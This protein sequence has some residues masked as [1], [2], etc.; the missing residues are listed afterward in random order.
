[1]S[2]CCLGCL[3][4][5][6]HAILL[7]S[8]E[9]RASIGDV[10]G[11]CDNFQVIVSADQVVP[12]RTRIGG[13]FDRT[14]AVVKLCAALSPEERAAWNATYAGWQA[15]AAQDVSWLN[16][17]AIARSMC[18]MGAA[19]EREREALRTKC[20]AVGPSK[21]VNQPHEASELGSTLKWV[22]G[23][24]IVVAGVYALKSF[25]P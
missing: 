11:D 10:Y 13:E 7:A 15:L 8:E 12:F 3:A 18:A 19:L 25:L 17:N 16:A 22:A 21:V 5:N 1:M 24:A 4:G 14:D 9:R 23:A 6:P 2:S 20:A